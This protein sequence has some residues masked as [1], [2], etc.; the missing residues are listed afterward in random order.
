M[1]N[2]GEGKNKAIKW[3]T[4]RIGFSI[5]LFNKE[6][7][8]IDFS[9]LFRKS[10]LKNVKIPKMQ[11]PLILPAGILISRG[12]PN[13]N[14][15]NFNH[16]SSKKLHLFR[17][18]F[19][20]SIF[21][22]LIYCIAFADINLNISTRNKQKSRIESGVNVSLKNT[23]YGIDDMLT[24]DALGTAV[25]NLIPTSVKADKT[26]I[27]GY[28]LHQNYPN[29]FNPETVIRYSLAKEGNVNIIIYNIL[30]QG[31]KHLVNEY[32]QRGEHFV[33]W[34]GRTDN[35]AIAADG[36]YIYRLVSGD[37]TEARKM[38]HLKGIAHAPVSINMSSVSELY[39]TLGKTADMDSIEVLVKATK[40]DPVLGLKVIVP[41][42]RTHKLPL[43]GNYNLVIE[44]DN[45]NQAPVFRTALNDTTVNEGDTLA[46]D[47]KGITYDANSDSL[48]FSFENNQRLRLVNSGDGYFRFAADSIGSG[49][50]VFTAS[51]KEFAAKDSVN[52]NVSGVKTKPINPVIYNEDELFANALNVRDYFTAHGVAIDRYE[53]VGFNNVN[54]EITESGQVNL[55]NKTRDFN[56][57]ETGKIR[58]YYN[59][60]FVEA[61]LEVRVNAMTDVRGVHRH[62]Y[63]DTL[64]KKAKITIDGI[65]HETDINGNFDVQAAPKGSYTITARTFDNGNPTGYI[66]TVNV[67][68]D[69]DTTFDIFSVPYPTTVS[70]DTFKAFIEEGNTRRS[71]VQND[72][73]YI[74]FYNEG[75]MKYVI[76]MNSPDGSQY[77]LTSADQDFLENVIRT[78]IF[79]ALGFTMPIEK[80]DASYTLP[81]LQER[82]NTY[83]V[84]GSYTFTFGGQIENNSIISCSGTV[85]AHNV[86]NYY[87]DQITEELVSGI[88]MPFEVG[89]SISKEKSLLHRSSQLTELQEVDKMAYWLCRK[90]KGQHIDN[91]LKIE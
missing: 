31:V 44:L 71:G 43:R 7:F 66:R 13:S 86:N 40:Q 35:G 19:Y 61:P 84:A 22:I 83:H 36:I 39:N 4:G 41:Y 32:E 74:K 77:N 23:S 48:V 59:N 78:K 75:D 91:V 80:K 52:V 10:L 27:E 46:F 17:L 55:S 29:P 21:S 16:H 89:H 57:T 54:V 15:Q 45:L 63:P 20:S 33:K 9:K 6:I 90:F 28:A 25:L 79:D 64:G 67:I 73:G 56:G 50:I 38:T 51:D 68:T 18:L 88:F 85:Y 72:L 34:D 76:M 24:T 8:I 30:G 14:N 81:P 60:K 2:G 3:N 70:A 82:R 65:E 42:E 11:C 1:H 49:N 53:A 87:I 37:F 26:R 69:K 5:N 47:I 12:P 62:I 58:A